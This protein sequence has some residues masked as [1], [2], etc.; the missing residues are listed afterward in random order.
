MKFFVNAAKRLNEAVII[1][2]S[3]DKQVV[4]L[5]KATFADQKGKFNLFF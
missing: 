2:I 5:L 3:I 4:Q 1:I